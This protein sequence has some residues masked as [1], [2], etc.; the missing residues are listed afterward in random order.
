MEG[1][2]LRILGLLL[3]V[4]IAVFWFARPKRSKV[5]ITESGI[6]PPGADARVERVTLLQSGPQGDLSLTARDAEWSRETE[7]FHLTDV[8]IRF[9]KESTSGEPTIGGTIV[10]ERGDASTNGREFA[11]EGKVVAETFDGYRLETSDVRYDHTT[12]QIM[13]NAPVSLSGPGLDVSGRGAQVDY[14][15]QR[16]EIRGRVRAHVVPQI[17]KEQVPEG[18]LPK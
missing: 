3:L 6:L 4:A 15:N 17:V 16:V 1:R 7:T 11:L 10:G 18:M 2:A 5:A 9:L 14:A 8:K 12:R 13:T